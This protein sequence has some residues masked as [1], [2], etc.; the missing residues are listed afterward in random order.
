M[1]ATTYWYP[2][3]QPTDERLVLHGYPVSNYYN[4][5]RAALIEAGVD[6]AI[7]TARATQDEAFLSC[8][9]MGKIPYLATPRG[10]IAETVAILEYLEDAGGGRRLYPTD[11][12]ERAK[13]RQVV[14]IVQVYIESPLRSLFPGAFMGGTNSAEAL[15]AARPV[16]ERAMRALARLV[17]PQPF[18]L[19][20][21]LT[22]AD[23]LA[24][25]TFDLGERAMR[26][27][28][29]ASLLDQVNGLREWDT[30]MRQR[31]SSRIV[32][33]DFSSAFSAYLRDKGAAWREPDL[34]D[35]AHA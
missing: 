35:P 12:F 33:S 28:Y 16:V 13:V 1:R 4:A 32:L 17:D 3:M 23:I 34:K 6:F 20:H 9:A 24:F 25:Y 19:G 15:G 8:S 18:L 7:E 31:E 27:A 30:M 21:E 2:S 14:N 5:A 29:D 11:P 26:F 10:F 22:H